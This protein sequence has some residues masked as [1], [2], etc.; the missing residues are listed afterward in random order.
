LKV[1]L[2]VELGYEGVAYDSTTAQWF[3]KLR[4]RPFGLAAAGRAQQARVGS[5]HGR[6]QD[7][8][9][10]GLGGG[11][12]EVDQFGVADLGRSAHGRALRRALRIRLQKAIGPQSGCGE[13]V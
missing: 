2:E 13:G 6:Q 7:P 11:Q 5:G 10:V 12:D 3:E 8:A 4:A 9:L 1:P